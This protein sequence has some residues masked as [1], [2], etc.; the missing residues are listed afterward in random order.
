MSREKDI[1]L[2]EKIETLCQ[3]LDTYSTKI[4]SVKNEVKTNRYIDKLQKLI[5]MISI[6]L[7]TQESN[8]KELKRKEQNFQNVEQEDLEQK[9][10]ENKYNP[11]SD[12]FLY[13]KRL[14]RLGG[15][16]QLLLEEL[17][18]EDKIGYRNAYVINEIKKKVEEREAE[19]LRKQ[20]LAFSKNNGLGILNAIKNIIQK[21]KET[22]KRNNHEK[23]KK[24]EI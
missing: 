15:N 7:E 20:M 12:E 10:K 11:F 14:N 18:N 24:E 2:F 8:K 19:E 17:K 5:D 13:K 4:I 21:I 23:C 1:E 6:K 16:I 22:F 3:R 9:L